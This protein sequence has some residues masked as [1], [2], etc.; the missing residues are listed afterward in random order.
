MDF[1]GLFLKKLVA[2]PHSVTFAA[3]LAGALP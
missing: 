1:R 2:F 3:R